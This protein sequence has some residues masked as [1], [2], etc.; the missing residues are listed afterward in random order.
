MDKSKDA[1]TEQDAAER[2]Y[3]PKNVVTKYAFATRVGYIPM[4][5]HK[6]NQ[7]TYILGPCIEGPENNSKHM[8]GVNDGHGQFGH[9]VS[10]YIKEGLLEIVKGMLEKDKTSHLKD[11]SALEKEYEDLLQSAFLKCDQRLCDISEKSKE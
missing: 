7:D 2:F 10:G 1:T 9:H 3:I 8:F 4:N 6:V 11:Q 5:P